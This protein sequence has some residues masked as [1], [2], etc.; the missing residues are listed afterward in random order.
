MNYTHR[1][2]VYQE[3]NHFLE[4]HKFNKVLEIGAGGNDNKNAI[5]SK[6]VFN[7]YGIFD[8]TG[9]DF[10]STNPEIIKMD[11]H[12]LEFPDESFDLV[13]LCHTFEHLENPIQALREIYRVL[14]KDGFV[15]MATPNPCEHHIIDKD[16]DHIFVLEPMQIKKLMA[17]CG[18]P[19]VTY[20]QSI[21]KGHQIPYEKDYNVISIGVKI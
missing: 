2:L 5:S 11:A 7:S 15:W 8:Y 1:D 4:Q 18:M 21:Y 6:E 20:K 13:Y 12:K 14:R 19:N 17:Y 9:I 16:F 10:M 3:L